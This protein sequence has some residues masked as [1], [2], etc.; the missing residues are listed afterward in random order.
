MLVRWVETENFRLLESARVELSPGVN[1]VT[2]ASNDRYV[3][4]VS[5]ISAGDI[6]ITSDS[7]GLEEGMKVNVVFEEE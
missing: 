2:G 1:V 3:E 4:I 6:V 5:G 7:D